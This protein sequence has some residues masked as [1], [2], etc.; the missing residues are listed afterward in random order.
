M[1][2]EQ[3]IDDFIIDLKNLYFKHG[4]ALYPSCCDGFAT[5]ITEIEEGVDQ[6]K[7]IKNNSV[8]N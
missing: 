8:H 5:I 7:W 6:L 4:L 3:Q 2:T 1:P